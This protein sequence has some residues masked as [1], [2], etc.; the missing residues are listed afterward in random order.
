VV[1]K[2]SWSKRRAHGTTHQ[3]PLTLFRLAEQNQLK[4]LPVVPFEIVTWHQAKVAHDCHIQVGSTLYSVPY[5]YVGK[6]VA[7]KLGSDIVY[8]AARTLYLNRT[9]FKGMW[10]HNSRG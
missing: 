1:S 7:V 10:R 6:T 3:Q 9:C 8:N 5:Q 4:P 2:S